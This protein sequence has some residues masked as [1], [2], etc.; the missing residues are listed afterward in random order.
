MTTVTFA[1]L[2]V[3]EPLCRT[4]AASNYETPTPIQAQ[5]IPA[6]L[7]GRD[8][9]GLAQTG[10]GKTAAFAL[11]ILQLLAAKNE[12]RQPKEARA[13]ILAPTRELA[14]QISQ[15][16]E[17]YGKN[18]KLRHTVIFGGVNQFRQVKAMTGG[19]DILVATPGRLLDLMNQK[20]VNLGRTSILVLDE[21]DRMLDMGFVRDVRKIIAA[22][23]RQRQS[24]LFSA[25]MPSSIEHLAD[26]ILQQPVRVE[27]T[28]EV[29][30]V[31]KIDQRVLHVDGKRKRELLAKLLDNSELSRVIVFTRTKHCANRVSEQ[32]DKSGVLSEAIH[33]NKSQ[34]ARQRALDMFRNGKAR[35][36]VATDI[37]ARGIDVSGITHVIN[38]E[39]P[40][41][42][43]SYVHRIGRTARAGKSGIALSFCD[44]SER[45]HLRSIEKLTKR[46]LTIVD[47]T[48]WLGEQVAV[49]TGEPAAKRSGNRNGGG[50]RNGNNNRQPGKQRRFGGKPGGGGNRAQNGPKNGQKSGQQSRRQSTAS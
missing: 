16:I 12:K 21:A 36:L 4:L 39:L 24:L 5:A 38:Y 6:L 43:E 32:L 7:E 37:A 47:T 34:G 2:G 41:E 29:V 48:E 33:G 17:S 26:E 20:H 30:T 42:P 31:D 8:L 3:A 46:P 10:T 23:P 22:M 28:P 15:S 9:L 49:P 44:A 50:P 45:A 40:N 14:M 13:L 11:P 27:V 1:D 19:V 18:F 25:T 35:V